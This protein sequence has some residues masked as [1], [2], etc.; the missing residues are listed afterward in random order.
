[1]IPER[2]VAVVSV[3]ARIRNVAFAKR[4]SVLMDSACSGLWMR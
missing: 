1:M 3:P 2:A 4:D